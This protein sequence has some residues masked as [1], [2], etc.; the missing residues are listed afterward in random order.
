V[1]QSS[2]LYIADE[3]TK[4]GDNLKWKVLIMLCLLMFTAAT[5]VMDL[6]MISPL[7]TLGINAAPTLTLGTNFIEP[8][9]GDPVDVDELPK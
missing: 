7:P 4:G 5:M 3:T 1:A 9:G 8:L 2:I 6:A